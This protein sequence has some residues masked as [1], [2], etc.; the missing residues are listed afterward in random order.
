V[1][2][3]AQTCSARIDCTLIVVIAVQLIAGVRARPRSNV[4]A[5][6]LAARAVWLQD[7]R[8]I[9]LT[10]ELIVGRVLAGPAVERRRRRVA[11]VT[12]AW[13]TIVAVT[14]GVQAAKLR[15]TPVNRAGVAVVT[16]PLR[17]CS[18]LSGHA[19]CSCD[20]NITVR[21]G[22]GVSAVGLETHVG[23]FVTVTDL[24][25]IICLTFTLPATAQAYE[26]TG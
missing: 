22:K 11:V 4:V 6:A 3:V 16:G 26:G 17:E 19:F 7:T 12:S 24:A 5:D 18:A 9:D 15:V 13:V 21:T 14:L 8:I 1:R 10:E 23:I 2:V 20:A 25:R